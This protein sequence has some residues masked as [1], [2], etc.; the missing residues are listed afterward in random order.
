MSTPLPEWRFTIR[1]FALSTAQA[2]DYV[3]TALEPHIASIQVAPGTG[4]VE[5]DPPLVQ[6]LLLTTTNHI[7]FD[8]IVRLID[9]TRHAG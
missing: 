1:I 9:P 8:D 3:R 6:R 4:G 7:E 5:V 2:V